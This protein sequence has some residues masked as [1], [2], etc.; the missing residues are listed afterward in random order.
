MTA[1][2]LFFEIHAGS[3]VP[4]VTVSRSDSALVVVDMQYHDAHPKGCFNLAVDAIHP[5]SMDYFNERT[6][7]T[8]VPAIARLLAAFRDR[9]LPVVHLRLGSQFEDYRDLAPRLRQWV[10]AVEEKSGMDRLF[11]AGHRD[12]AIREELAPQGDEAVVDKTAFGAF[13]GSNIDE[14][15]QARGIRNLAFTG[16]STNC[17]VESTVRDAAERGYGCVVV[18]EATADYDESAHVASLRALAFNHAR[19]VATGAEVVE[20][21]D[22][23]SPL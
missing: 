5:G 12:F 4:T 23:A 21:L 10:R 17:C 22:T 11:W 15:L 16:I 14:L 3:F 13:N 7:S 18:D 8:T 6:E 2:D 1:D 19:V 20:A 9:G